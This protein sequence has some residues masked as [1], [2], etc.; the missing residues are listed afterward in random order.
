VLKV[1]VSYSRENAAAARDLANDIRELGHVAWFDQELAG[2]QTWWNEILKNI[3]NCDA[4]VFV[5]TQQA[6]SS[7]ACLRE[8][9]YASTLGKTIVPVLVADGVSVNLLP[10]ALSQ[11]HI[12]DYRNQSRNSAFH[13]GKAFATGS[14]A[15]P[16]PDPLPEAP[17]VPISY[18][19]GLAERIASPSTLSYE[20][21][22]ALVVDLRRGVHEPN[23]FDDSRALLERLRSRRD[24]LA[25]IRDEVDE[26]LRTSKKPIEGMKQKESGPKE[27]GPKESGQKDS[28]PQAPTP[29]RRERIASAL[30]GAILGTFIGFLAMSSIKPLSDDWLFGLLTGAGATVAGAIS[31]KRLGVVLPAIA[32]AAAAW[33]GCL[34]FI[35]SRD[36]VAV[37]GVFGAPAGAILGAV[38]GVVLGRMRARTKQT[39]ASGV[40]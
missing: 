15:G 2:G 17:E 6:L 11:I 40:A 32:V 37:G 13:L 3:R 36:S 25:A 16:L 28:S 31:G 38:A 9:S 1:F 23:A 35:P 12:I 39:S 14:S 33:I 4:F 5:L 24:L 8:C 34:I 18:L 10:P 20:Q 26:L 7:T 21:Q 27:S 29:S 30:V 19:G 22:S